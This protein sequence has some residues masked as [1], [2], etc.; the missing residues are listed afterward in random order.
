ML[1]LMSGT[2]QMNRSTSHDKNQLQTDR[3]QFQKMTESL[4]LTDF[5]YSHCDVRFDKTG[6]KDKT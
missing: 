2:E 6:L 4:V 3:N 1:I 5:L